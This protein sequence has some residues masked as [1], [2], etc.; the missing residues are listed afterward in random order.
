M[1]RAEAPLSLSL[2]DRRRRRAML[3]AAL[4]LLLGWQMLAA[5]EA[6]AAAG[7][8][9]TYQ[10]STYPSADGPP[11]A[12]KP[13]SKLWH[14]DGAWWGL[15]R[16]SRGVTIHR[17]VNHVWQDTGTVVDER[18][19]SSGDAL[20][21]GTRL[22]VAS[23]V[24]AGALLVVRFTYNVGTDVYTRDLS[25]QIHSSGTESITIAQD[26][27]ARLWVSFTR[28]SRVFVAHST[29]SHSQW[30]APFVIP[31]ADNTVSSDDISAV[32]S[33]AGR[34]GVMYS[35][36]GNAKMW[37]AVHADSAADSSW[38]LETAL[39]GSALADDHINLKSLLQ[40]DAGRIYAAT[41][42]SRT[43]AGGPSIMVLQR[44]SSGGWTSAV[45]ARVEDGLTRAQLALDRTGRRLIVL[46]AKEGG[47]STVYYKTA[48]LGAL[49][50]GAGRGS[51]FVTWSGTQMNDPSTTKQAVSAATGL[52]VLT[53]D[54]KSSPKR[55]Y[56]A[57][58]ALG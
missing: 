21:D 57:E 22:F 20:W 25:K 41:K 52:V 18:L 42:T 4:V 1:Q 23:R 16:T 46:M 10:G 2:L 15:L 11:S 7:P 30:T 6:R 31:V 51:A 50:F 39:S 56:H 14:N 19:H 32:I 9:V 49:S 27:R 58:M 43:D 53:S 37:F 45:A 26:S 33:F 24:S 29:T 54:D 47:G 5:P 13:Q 3:G 35:D 48:P 38:T 17:L 40:D 28:G 55:Y 12:D 36:Q 44:S 34:I 8:P